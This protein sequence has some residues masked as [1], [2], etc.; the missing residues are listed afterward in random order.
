MNKAVYESKAEVL[1]LPIVRDRDLDLVDVE[2]VKEGSSWYL[3][4]YVD[5]TGGITVDDC[6][7]VSRAWEEKL[8]QEDFIAESYVLEVSSPGLGRPLKKEK[9][10]VRNK[11]KEV[12]IHLF[13]PVDHEKTWTGVLSSWKQDSVTI[14]SSDY[15]EEERE[16]IFDRQNIALIREAFDW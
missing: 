15:A 16:V 10:Y 13:K 8:D 4:A 6:E 9:D 11:G 7:A 3:R 1:L 14:S 5:K 12:E 2:F